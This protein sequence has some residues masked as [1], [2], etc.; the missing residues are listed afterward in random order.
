MT[1]KITLRGFAVR[2]TVKG[3]I[4]AGLKKYSFILSGMKPL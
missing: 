3:T 2:V 4:S 1:L